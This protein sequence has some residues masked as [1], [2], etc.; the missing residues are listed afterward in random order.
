MIAAY[1]NTTHEA[2]WKSSR[3]DT[4]LRA[5]I[6]S[7]LISSYNNNNEAGLGGWTVHHFEKNE[8]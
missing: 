7:D 4:C 6:C 2:V 1:S 8:K 3:I 5:K